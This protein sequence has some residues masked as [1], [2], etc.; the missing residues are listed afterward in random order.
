MNI[1]VNS[2]HYVAPKKPI[3]TTIAKGLG[4]IIILALVAIFVAMF[5]ITYSLKDAEVINV[6]GSLRMQSYRLAYDIQSQS[7][8]LTQHMVSM[9][10]S[11]RSSSMQS[12]DNVLVP[13]TIREQY[14]KI[15]EQWSQLSSQIQSGNQNVYLHQVSTLVDELDLFVLNLQRF[16]ENKLK[17]FAL[18]GAL[19]LFLIFGITVLIVRFTRNKV[20]KPLAQLVAASQSI[21]NKNFD[22]QLDMNNQTELDVLNLCYQ[23]MARE[24]ALFYHGLELAV[25]EKTRELQQANDSLKIL[26]NCSEALSSSRLTIH[27]FQ[28]VLDTFKQVDGIQACRLSIDENEGGQIQLVSGHC[29]QYSSWKSF[30]LEENGMPLGKLEWQQTQNKAV[31]L[32]M[33]SLSHIIAR[34]LYFSHNQKQTEQ[35]ILM[36]ERATI[37][38]ELHDSLAQSLSYLKI[39]VTLLKRSLNQDLCAKR[40]EVA[41]DI[42]QEVDEVLAQAYTQLRELLSTFRLKIEE[43]HFGEALKQL[44]EPLKAH[45]KAQLIVD[46]QLLSIDLDAQQQVHLLQFIR[47]AVL[48]AIKHASADH[49]N[50]NCYHEN[51]TI[52][53]NVDDDGVGFDINKPKLNHYGLSIMKERASRLKA[54]FKITS[55][56]GQGSK[57]S[58]QMEL[59]NLNPG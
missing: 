48:N 31:N 58:L 13:N 56:R 32:V 16:S 9:D 30:S 6:A 38:R 52:H 50:V 10:K 42:I 37:A 15:V 4:S 12:L 45:T 7:P 5:T 34:A 53:I 59:T 21:Q 55:E 54:D 51:N 1:L 29:D 35:L 39:Q 11:L 36:Q 14:Q 47:E 57:V 40:C 8:Q 19:C 22:I 44:L 27:D 43:A 24:L 23:S 3:A 20:V 25:D 2:D 28:L 33:E 18:A 41:T 49:I 26:Y 17:M 46:N